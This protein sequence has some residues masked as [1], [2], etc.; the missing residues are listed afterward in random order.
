MRYI[1]FFLGLILILSSCQSNH[2]VIDESVIQAE[3]FKTATN[4]K[5]GTL[6]SAS[7][8]NHPDYMPRHIQG[9]L[10]LIHQYR[11]NQWKVG[12][13]ALNAFMINIIKEQPSSLDLVSQVDLQIITFMNFDRFIFKAKLGKEQQMLAAQNLKRLMEYTKPFEWRLL[14]EGLILSKPFI[15]SDNYSKYEDYIIQGAEKSIKDPQ[16]VTGEGYDDTAFRLKSEAIIALELLN[17]D[18]D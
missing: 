6:Y 8:A 13:E 5:R 7:G 2:Q 18:V 3:K 4:V 9:A 12:A 1:Y 17:Q 16:S 11:N 15:S 10:K 14:A